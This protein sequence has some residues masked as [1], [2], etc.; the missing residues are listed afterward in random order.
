MI[1]STLAIFSRD[2]KKFLSNPFVLLMT[3]IMPIAYLVVFGN[4][5][6]GA[7]TGI[8]IALV[9]EDPYLEQ[10]PLFQATAETLGHMAEEGAAETFQVRVFSGEASA[11][12]ALAGGEVAAVVVVPSEVSNTHAVRLYLDSS[13]FA[14]PALVEASVRTLVLQS[15][16]RAPLE[17]FRLYGEID[18]FQFFGVGVIVM[19][20]FMSTMM[21]GVLSLIRD[22]EL[23]IIEGYLV[24]PVK[25]SSIVLGTIGSGTVKGFFSGAVIYGVV[26]AITGLP[27]PGA[28]T[29]LLVLLVLVLISA[30]L[31]SLV[32]FIAGRLKNQQS[33]AAVNGFLNLLL[34]MTSGAFYPTLGMPDWLRALTVANPEF[35]AVHALRALVLRGQG[36]EVIAV[37]LA[38]M[39]L[40]A[41]TCIV[42]GITTF[43]RTLE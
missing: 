14:T 13:E 21:G 24:T 17:V 8:P 35:Y 29:T 7:I 22:W 28:G 42:F 19:A 3:L 27:V 1:R 43:R 30:G 33:F 39:G 20:I 25:R 15:G 36:L 5:M 37:D 16:H 26:M 32:F 6:G 40:F 34:F 41:V 4:A 9:Q 38:A 23:G 2:F 11:K 10:T 31:T 18:Y 12:R